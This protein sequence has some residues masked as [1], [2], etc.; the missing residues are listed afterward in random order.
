MRV[1]NPVEEDNQ[2]CNCITSPRMAVCTKGH[3]TEGAV[4]LPE[5][6]REGEWPCLPGFGRYTGFR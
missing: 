5:G 2:I 3:S 1:Q 6:V 4:A